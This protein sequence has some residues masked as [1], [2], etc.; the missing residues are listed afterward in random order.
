MDVDQV[1]RSIEQQ[2]LDFADFLERLAPE[3]W[4]EPSLCEGWRVRDVAA[5]VTLAARA[6]P[7]EAFLGVLRAGGNINRWIA[8]DAKG[9]ADRPPQEL[10]AELRSVASSR[11]HPPGTKPLDPLVDILVHGQDV[12]RP[13][14][15]PRSMPTDAAVAAA[16]R[17]WSMGF[18]FRARKRNRGVRL[19]ATNAPWERG[20]GP[21]AEGPIEAVL[22]QLAGRP[23]ALDDLGGD[24]ADLLR[25]R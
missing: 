1:W 22:L 18:P 19:R 2:R 4:D 13:V 5:H 9:R 24:G 14:G 21:V 11:H 12:A 17:L 23:A 20:D 16:E 3:Q 6:R 25:S 7:K 10:I 8:Q 15:L